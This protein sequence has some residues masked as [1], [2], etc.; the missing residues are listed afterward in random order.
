MIDYTQIGNELG[1]SRHTIKEW[2]SILKASF[3]ITTLPPYFEN[4]GK[5]I[6]KSS[7]LVHI[8]DIK[9]TKVCVNFTEYS[10]SPSAC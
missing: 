5:R 4:L 10:P 6:I 1:L 9:K 2:I 3:I 8:F 7:K